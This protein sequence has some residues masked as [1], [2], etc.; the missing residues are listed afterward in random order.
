VHGACRIAAGRQEVLKL[1]N[2]A[3]ERDWGWAPEYVEAMWRILQQERP[4]DFVIAT[5]ETHRLEDFVAEAF[6]LIGLDWRKHVETDPALL[7]PTDLAV[8]RANPA[9]AREKLGWEAK[10]RMR[11]VVRQMLAAAQDEVRAMDKAK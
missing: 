3:V 7:R 10:S 8:S 2:L 1:G 6:R 11:D 4:D 5:G 9:K